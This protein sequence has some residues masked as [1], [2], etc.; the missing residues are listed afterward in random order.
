MAN[1][2]GRKAAVWY[3]FYYNTRRSKKVLRWRYNI[4]ELSFS[5]IF[6]TL[7]D[8]EHTS[9][10]SFYLHMSTADT[11][12]SSFTPSPS[13]NR[14][15]IA[16]VVSV[17]ATAQLCQR[18]TESASERARWQH[19][20]NESPFVKSGFLDHIPRYPRHTQCLF[21]FLIFILYRWSCY[22]YCSIRLKSTACRR[23]YLSLHNFCLGCQF[24]FNFF[25]RASCC[26]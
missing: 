21:L 19:I 14:L 25:L 13:L 17:V 10:F 24:H 4:Y 26:R 6:Y 15:V 16:T 9:A 18:A 22:C 1:V 12:S 3:I 20:T 8:T 5:A 2:N 7:S 11:S 23:L